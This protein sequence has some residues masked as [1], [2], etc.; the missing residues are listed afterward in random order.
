MRAANAGNY[1]HKI[2]FQSATP[3]TDQVNSFGERIPGWTDFWTTWASIEPLS[4]R[5]LATLRSQGGTET[6]RIKCRY[7]PGLNVTMQIRYG[8]A[9]QFD[10]AFDGAFAGGEGAMPPRLFR[11]SSIS[12]IEERNY[13]LW[14]MAEEFLHP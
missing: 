5:E 2:T 3:G 4:G 12:N 14:I 6:H 10:D 9:D 1:R 7:Y 13:E 8:P 11:I